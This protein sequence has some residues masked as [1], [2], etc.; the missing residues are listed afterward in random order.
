MSKQLALRL[1]GVLAIITALYHAISGDIILR[2]LTIDPAEQLDFVRSTHQ[3]GSMGWVA[4]GIL[5]SVAANLDSQQA[6]NWIVGV[7]V[8]MYGFPAVGTLFLSD[9]EINVGGIMLAMVVV[10]AL[11]GRKGGP[12][13][14]EEPA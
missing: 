12:T 6:R 8:V 4:G 5:L 13:L 1:S 7:L 9:G 3:L 10:L 2:A 11:V 14:E